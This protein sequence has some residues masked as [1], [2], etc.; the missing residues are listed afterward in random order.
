MRA[1]RAV[2]L[3]AGQMD[4]ARVLFE[5]SPE[6]AAFHNIGTEAVSCF[7]AHFAAL[8]QYMARWGMECTWTLS[9][10]M[11]MVRGLGTLLLPDG[12]PAVDAALKWL[13]PSAAL[14]AIAETETAW[15]V[16]M[17]G[18]QHPSLL[19]ALL[20]A[21]LG[22]WEVAAEIAEG[23][24]QRLLQPLT[25]IE[26]WRL[27]ARARAA[28]TGAPDAHAALHSAIEEAKA[29]GYLWLELLATRELCALGGC[30][31]SC[32]DQVTHPVPASPSHVITT[33]HS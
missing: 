7:E 14:L 4:F 25:R 32:V 19:C 28:L 13:P 33:A 21:R 18:C 29:A 27:L 15:D 5:S 9:S 16:F 12:D 3:A 8:G 20:Y 17:S 11:L 23:L 30:A 6:G 2:A 10:A 31:Q 24:T 1:A 26:A 22:R